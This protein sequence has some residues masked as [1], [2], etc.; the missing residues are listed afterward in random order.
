[1]LRISDSEPDAITKHLSTLGVPIEILPLSSLRYG[2]YAWNAD[3]ETTIGIE[4]KTFH[5][6]ITSY[7]QGRLHAQIEGCLA[8][9]THTI[10]LIEGV[11]DTDGY[12]P[13]INTF[14][15]HYS[16]FKRSSLPVIGNIHGFTKQLLNLQLHIPIIYSSH[17]TMTAQ[18]IAGLYRKWE[19]HP[20]L[21]GIPQKTLRGIEA[22][23]VTIKEMALIRS[24]P[25]ITKTA[26][27]ALIITYGSIEKICQMLN[28]EEKPPKLE[29]VGPKTIEALKEVLL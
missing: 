17:Y 3:G 6:F 18:I 24:V 7:Q 19:V 2:D 5:D 10:L 20:L 14:Y 4:R 21:E 13:H 8:T 9:Y 1:M 22:N 23:T 28:S 27:H 29:G 26:A 25:R 16:G 11:I 15:R 12:D